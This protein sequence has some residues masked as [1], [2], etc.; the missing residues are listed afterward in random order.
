LAKQYLSVFEVLND[1]TEWMSLSQ[2]VALTLGNIKQLAAVRWPFIVSNFN[3]LSLSIATAANGDSSVLV[4]LEDL[5]NVVASYNLGNTKYNPFASTNDFIKYNPILSLISL[6]TL[7]LTPAEAV[8]VNLEVQRIQKLGMP[9]FLDAAAFLRRQY[10]LDAQ[11]VGLGDPDADALMGIGP[12]TT[13]RAATIDDLVQLQQLIDLQQIIEGIVFN[14][15]Q[16]ENKPPNLLAI[17]N[18]NI[19]P[20]SPVSIQNIYTSYTPIPFEISVESMA[21]KY[22]GTVDRWYELATINNL[23]PP[24]V[25]EVGVKYGLLAPGAANNVIVSTDSTDNISVGLKVRVGSY[26]QRE[27]SRVVEK[28][29]KNPNNTSI[30]FL[31]DIQNISRFKPLEGAYIRVYAP[32]TTREGEFIKIPSSGTPTQ[33]ANPTPKSDELRGLDAAFI[34]FGI[35]IARDPITHDLQMDPNGNFKYA[36]G[37]QAIRNAVMNV[38]KTQISELPFHPTYGVDAGIGDRF[39]GTTD[40]ALIF[41]S[42]LRATILS[43]SRFSDVHIDSVDATGSSMSLKILVKVSGLESPIPLSFTA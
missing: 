14:L 11:V 9:D 29:I 43:D 10:A 32:G 15:G 6:T 42:L 28:I 18:Q 13:Q 38:L 33:S 12:G 16:T 34:A 22:L 1:T 39:Y 24:Y 2:G 7:Q 5:A 30:L 26:S 35:D 37:T 31:S 20:A 3:T 41:A 23:Q 25:D 8:V 21:K 19:D 17:A 40:E 4:P 27:E 36:Y